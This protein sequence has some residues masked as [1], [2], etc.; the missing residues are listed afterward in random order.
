MRSILLFKFMKC[1]Q[2]NPTIIDK[3]SKQGNREPHDMTPKTSN[4]GA[5][6]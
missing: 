4:L 6:V 2:K 5:I 1:M 3:F